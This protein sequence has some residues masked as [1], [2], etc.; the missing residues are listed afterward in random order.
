MVPP[1]DVLLSLT[2]VFEAGFSGVLVPGVERV[3]TFLF[4]LSF[5]CADMPPLISA[6]LLSYWMPGSHRF[7]TT[8]IRAVSRRHWF[9]YLSHS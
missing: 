1:S 4:P 3:G 9:R 5:C 8:Q 2:S 7:S 6:L